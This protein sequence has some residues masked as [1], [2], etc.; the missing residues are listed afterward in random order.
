M[1][2]IISIRLRQTDYAGLVTL[3]NELVAGLTGNGNFTTPLPTL[4]ALQAAITD[5]EDAITTWGPKGSRGPKSALLDLRAKAITLS[6]IIK[7]L[8]QYVQ[9]TAQ[10]TAGSD[11]ATM[12]AIMSTSGFDVVTSRNPQGPLQAVENFRKVTT[13]KVNYYQVKL[14]WRKPLG[15]TTRSNVKSYN[16]L[17]S[18]T[19]VLSAAV[20][21]GATTRT[22]FVDTNDTGTPQTWHYWVVP[23][24]GAGEGTVSEMLTVSVF[25]N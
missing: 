25:S 16:V 22:S 20:K 2:P 18:A 10:T 17:R 19:P 4:V 11:Y 12:A 8:S 3:G 24:N 13:P 9:N 7:S 14:M 5:V 21:V 15:L 1:K 6:Q 23:V